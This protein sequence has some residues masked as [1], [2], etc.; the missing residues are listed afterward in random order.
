MLTEEQQ[1]PLRIALIKM[2]YRDIEFL[3]DG[4]EGAAF[5][6]GESKVAKFWFD[7]DGPSSFEIWKGAVGRP[8]LE[9]ALAQIYQVSVIKL[10][11]PYTALEDKQCITYD[12]LGLTVI[13]KVE[14][15]DDWPDDGHWQLPEEYRDL[16]IAIAEHCMNSRFALAKSM[17]TPGTQHIVEAVEYLT[18]IFGENVLPGLGLT[19]D[20]K[21]VIY[22]MI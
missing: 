18:G 1:R 19:K 21:L 14:Q 7:W 10:E 22:D 12:Y 16:Q 5:A 17:T 2:G 13:E 20:G 3:D 4:G 15:I 11:P 8:E 6:L 9:D